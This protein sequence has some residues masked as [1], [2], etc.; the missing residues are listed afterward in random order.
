MGKFFDDRDRGDVE[1]I[2]RVGFKRADTALA[3]NHVV[4]S[5]G[6]NVFGG[7]QEFFHRRR[8]AALEKNRFANFAESAQKKIILHVASADLIDVHVVAHHFDLGGVHN[9]TDGEK[10]ELV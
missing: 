4:I 6:K 3:Q 5:T 8:E 10:A 1:R 9:F 7:K 2:S